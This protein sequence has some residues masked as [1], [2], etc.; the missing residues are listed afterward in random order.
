V[1]REGFLAASIDWFIEDQAFNLVSKFDRR[2]RKT[3]KERQLADGRGGAG[4]EPNHRMA[5][6]P[7]SLSIIQPSLVVG[8]PCQ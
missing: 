4:E 3:E 7:G 1:F 8:A 6:K 2:H 5:R